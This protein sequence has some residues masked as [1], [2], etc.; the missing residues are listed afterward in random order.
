MWR[1]S[2]DILPQ[3]HTRVQTTIRVHGQNTNI[4][5]TKVPTQN[6][7]NTRINSTLPK[8][9]QTQHTPTHPK[10]PKTGGQTGTTRRQ[11]GRQEDRPADR[12]TVRDNTRTTLTPAHHGQLTLN[13]CESTSS[14][15]MTSFRR[16]RLSP[17]SSCSTLAGRRGEGRRGHVYTKERKLHKT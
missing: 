15:R 2:P 6:M 9:L 3:Q 4:K 17:S 12:Q 14:T 13:S 16:S 5:N 1:G 8:H 11:A 10:K 7:L